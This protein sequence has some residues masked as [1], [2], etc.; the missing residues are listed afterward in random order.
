M[1]G[2]GELHRQF[3]MSVGEQV[4]EQSDATPVLRIC[5]S[6]STCGLCTDCARAQISQGM[7]W[8]LHRNW[9]ARWLWQGVQPHE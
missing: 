1:E 7:L 9:T 8:S 4:T 6:L 2:A 5:I 3:T